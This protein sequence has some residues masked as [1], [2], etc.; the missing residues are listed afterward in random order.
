MPHGLHRRDANPQIAGEHLGGGFDVELADVDGQVGGNQVN[1]LLKDAATVDTFD[2]D[3]GHEAAAG[4][5]PP[6]GHDARPVGCLKYLCM[7][8]IQMV[9]LHGVVVADEA[10]YYGAYVCLLATHIR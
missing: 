8:A 5:L 3:V 1:K 4:G 10:L 6:C 9:N 2:V 7:R